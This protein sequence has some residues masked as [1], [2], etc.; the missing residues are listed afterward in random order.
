MAI[1]V[2]MYVELAYMLCWFPSSGNILPV[3][4][5]TLPVK[6][7]YLHS[8]TKP[9]CSGKI[10][11]T[12]KHHLWACLNNCILLNRRV[13]AWNTCITFHTSNQYSI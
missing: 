11:Q 10:R 13:D 3:E 4:P 6:T 8:L 9:R 2:I 5:I 12:L 7:R 1:L